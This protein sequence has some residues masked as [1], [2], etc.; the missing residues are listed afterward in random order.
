MSSKI[1]GMILLVLS[2]L[3]KVLYFKSNSR[4]VHNDELFIEACD[5]MQI[6]RTNI[7][8]DNKLSSNFFLPS[9]FNFFKPYMNV[10]LKLGKERDFIMYH[11]L[12]HYKNKHI[13]KIC[14]IA[15][16]FT[17][18]YP[19][20]DNT[21]MT[22]LLNCIFNLYIRN[23][24]RYFEME[25]DLEACRRSSKSS[26]EAMIKYFSNYLDVRKMIESYSP[27]VGYLINVMDTHPHTQDRIDYLT[28]ETEK[29]ITFGKLIDSTLI[30]LKPE[31]SSNYY[32][33]KKSSSVSTTIDHL[34]DDSNTPPLLLD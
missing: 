18:M 15:S 13:F 4:Q 29:K 21:V 33:L 24:M 26:I 11:E 17:L 27:L 16:V 7:Y 5:E 12:T 34:V 23:K 28:T 2:P 20:I 3:V 25:A 1:Y 31:Y 6:D 19:R 10:D 14:L 22:V 9:C 30:S 32:L 8:F